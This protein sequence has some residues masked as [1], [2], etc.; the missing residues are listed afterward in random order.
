VRGQNGLL[1][2][3]RPDSRFRSVHKNPLSLDYSSVLCRLR[4][5]YRF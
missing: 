4:H 2:N 3:R 1:R 5:G